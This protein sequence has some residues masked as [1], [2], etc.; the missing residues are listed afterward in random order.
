MVDEILR[1][2]VSLVERAE[3]AGFMAVEAR[4]V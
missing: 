4:V 2:E 3:G 1:R